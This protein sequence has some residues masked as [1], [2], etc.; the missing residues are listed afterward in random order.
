MKRKFNAYEKT[1]YEFA[2]NI[3]VVCPN[4]GRKAIIKSKG[5]LQHKNENEVKLVCTECGMNKYYSEKPKDKYTTKDGTEYKVR[6]LIIGGNIDP[7]F[8]LPLWLQKETP[9]GLL[10]A[11]NYEHLDFLE[12][13]INAELRSREGS[14]IRNKSL[15]SRLPKWMTSK[16]NRT[17]ILSGIKKLKQK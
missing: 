5:F 15:G 14:P 7:Y 13:H 1:I 9:N 4:C 16:K 2:N 3:F 10:W 17:E 6:N 12:N 11:Y 8:S